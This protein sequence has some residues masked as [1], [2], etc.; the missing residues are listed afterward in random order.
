[1]TTARFTEAAWSHQLRPCGAVDVMKT[2][3]EGCLRPTSNPWEAA[4]QL[5]SNGS[6]TDD[7]E[8]DD[9][10]VLVDK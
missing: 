8:D 10:L 4:D 6:D 9:E 7:D 5:H 1:M 3:D 2:A